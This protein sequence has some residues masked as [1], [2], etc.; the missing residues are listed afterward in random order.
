MNLK[1]PKFRSE[2]H[3]KFV[4]SLPCMVCACMPSQA[5]HIRMFTD[6]GTSLKPSD[7]YTVPLCHKCHQEQHRIG[8]LA[9]WGGEDL[10]QRVIQ[11]AVSLR[12]KSWSSAL[13]AIMN[14]EWRK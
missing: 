8:E 4:R 11:F 1:T 14:F 2:K 12:S 7:H 6:G 10:I 3:L 5:A 13:T 9:F